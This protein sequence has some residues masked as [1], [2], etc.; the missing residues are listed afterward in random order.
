MMLNRF[1]RRVVIAVALS[2][3]AAEASARLC[4]DDVGGKDVPCSCGDVVVSDLVLTNDPVTVLRCRNEGLI[5]R[6]PIDNEGLQIDLNGKTLR[7]R[8]RGAGVWVMYGGRGGAR[9]FSNGGAAVI[10]GYGDGIVGRTKG[11]IGL[12]DNVTVLNSKRDGIRVFSES[13]EIRACEARNSGR[14]GFSVRGTQ[15]VI[16]SSRA[17][18]SRRFGFN[19]SGEIG[20]LGVRRGGLVAESSG[21]A[22]FNVSGTSH[23]IIDCIASSGGDGVVATGLAHEINGCAVYDNKEFGIRGTAASSR[24]GNNSAERNGKA[25]IEFGGIRL[26]DLG[27]NIG[28]DNGDPHGTRAPTQ[29]EIGGAPCQ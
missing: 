17:V 6:A 24:L 3:T 9:V 26:Q 20:S 27:G 12:I 10:D 18:Q 21:R 25:G 13:T 16:K 1:F 15:W 4:G 8:G 11:V 2:L 5:V 19:A 28:F 7:G 29:C 23:R 14:D 22:G